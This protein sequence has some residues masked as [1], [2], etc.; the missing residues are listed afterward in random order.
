MQLGQH[1]VGDYHLTLSACKNPIRYNIIYR[2][3]NLIIGKHSFPE[4]HMLIKANMLLDKKGENAIRQ[5]IEIGDKLLFKF[6][7]ESPQ[8]YLFKSWKVIR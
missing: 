4:L 1:I 3:N 8:W 6:W 7:V 5:A 2:I